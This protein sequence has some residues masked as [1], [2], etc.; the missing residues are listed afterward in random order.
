MRSEQSKQFFFEKKNQKTFDSAVARSPEKTATAAV[1]A[2]C[3]FF[4]KK[5]AFAF[6]R[7][8]QQDTQMQNELQRFYEFD[9]STAEPLGQ[10][11]TKS[12]AGLIERVASEVFA[13]CNV[14]TIRGC[15]GVGKTHV[16][17]HLVSL[18]RTH[19]YAVVC[20]SG[21][22]HGVAQVQSLLAQA[23]ASAERGTHRLVL[24]VDDAKACPE[25]VFSYV[26]SL[27]VRRPGAPPIQLVLLG[28]VGPWPGLNEP[29]LEDLREATTSCYILTPFEED[30]AAAYVRD[31]L[32]RHKLGQAG[33]RGRISRV[34]L[35]TLIGQSHGVPA[36]LDALVF[37]ALVQTEK[38]RKLSAA[39]ARRPSGAAPAK[40]P[41]AK[42]A[43]PRW[44][45]R[46]P[47]MALAATVSVALIATLAAT[48]LAPPRANPLMVRLPSA[49]RLL[50]STRML[51][52]QAAVYTSLAPL[53]A[54]T[55]EANAADTGN[56][57]A[58]RVG[59]GLVLVAAAGDDMRMLYDKVYRGVT[60]PPYRAVLAV[61]RSP[62]RP[63]GLV[64]FPEPPHGWSSR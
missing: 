48:A 2:F 40:L 62:L 54:R 57:D 17:R 53:P 34:A 11:Q 18:L 33:R 30:E 8:L 32:G 63:G 42:P 20:A 5:K 56:Q 12:R 36:L 37:D 59:P 50:A 43:R 15:R 25:A 9:W 52:V 39:P 44:T 24:V 22:V 13:G 16:G 29:G 51:P 47:S 3:F 55:V 46:L 49:V 23:A 27:V 21:A 45:P 58:G 19:G 64:V 28:E 41:S 14:L 26:W 7:R 1:K 10:F 38:L 6:F 35:R 31:K 61:N 4:S 60:P